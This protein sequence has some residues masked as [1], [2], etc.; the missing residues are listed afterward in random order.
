MGLQD[1]FDALSRV[2]ETLES[3]GRTVREVDV[4][5]DPDTAN[6]LDVRM[7]V[8]VSL[9]AA[10][11][12][13][14][15]SALTLQT[16]SLSD[17]GR[18]TVTCSPPDL[19]PDS[20]AS[21]AVVRTED[22][23]VHVD[24]GELVLTVIFQVE[25]SGPT[26]RRPTNEE[27]ESVDSA[28]DATAGPETSLASRLA[29]ARS[30]D[31]PAYEDTDYLRLL[32]ESCETFTEMS[33]HIEMDVAAETVRRYM[34]EAD[35]HEPS[36][37]GD[38]DQDSDSEGTEQSAC[39]DEPDVRADEPGPAESQSTQE[40]VP[41]EQLLT[42]GIGLPEGITVADIVETVADATAVYEVQRSLD[43]DHGQ[44]RELL[45]QLNLLELMLHRIDG[46]GQDASKDDVVRRIQQCTVGDA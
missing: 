6:V 24:D 30:D 32:Y 19:L 40:T 39:V 20:P 11:S 14:E 38:A 27:T 46:P 3:H 28:V 8:P 34:I 44:T 45:Q 7:V 41:D 37:Y 10:S 43:L 36:S 21:S 5:T 35:I 31:V 17:R 29:A 16:A 2:V 13:T 26:A 23:S 15:N 12:E 9:C 1:S 33:D 18:I 25:P 42:D 22:H 4:S